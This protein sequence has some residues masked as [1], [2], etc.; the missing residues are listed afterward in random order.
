VS[1]FEITLDGELPF[2]KELAKFLPNAGRNSKQ[3]RAS[4]GNWQ[5]NK[6]R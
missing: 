4:F 6:V 5:Q 2:D 1:H 3:L